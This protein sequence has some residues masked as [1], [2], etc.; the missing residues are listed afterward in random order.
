MTLPEA[1]RPFND[2]AGEYDSW[3]DSSPLFAIEV[4]AIR[5]AA[6][7]PM[8]PALEVGVGPGRFAQALDIAFGLDAAL[9]P[10][11]LARHRSII[12]I[13]GI[14]EQLPVRSRCMGTVYLLFTLCF[15]DDPA[16]VFR[17]IHRVLKPGGRLVIG[18]IPGHS[19]WGNYLRKKGR[20]N[21]PFYRFACFR[22]V[23]E[24]TAM[25]CGQGFE[26]L[27]SWSTLF[28]PPAQ[29]I[30]H[31]HPKPGAHEDGGFCVLLTR[32]KR[33]SCENC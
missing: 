22:T 3:Y 30:E 10:L 2:H 23:A 20:E 33:E 1:A 12:P 4:E 9:S 26:L 6:F 19:S 5:A 29:R 13:N 14:A 24:T 7:R 17:E 11:Q 27:D 16:A 31:E 8:P 28:Q 25:V 21:H 32:K 15:L 18:F